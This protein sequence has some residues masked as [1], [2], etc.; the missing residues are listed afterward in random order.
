MV[1]HW[2]TRHLPHPQGMDTSGGKIELISRVI[3]SL[4]DI[5]M[6]VLMGANIA[7]D[8]AKQDF[9]EATIGCSSAEQGAVLKT[10]FQRPMFRVNVV[11]DIAAVEL[12]GA[13]KVCGCGTRVG[14]EGMWVWH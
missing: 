11:S 9:C 8:V 4:A 7:Q 5:D 1:H 12:C 3:T 14:M 13:L 6:S 2:V 10:M